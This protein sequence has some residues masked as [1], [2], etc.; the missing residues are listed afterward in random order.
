MEITSYVLV[1]L[2][3]VVDL[4]FS[5]LSGKSLCNAAQ[6]CSS[7]NTA[8]N[9][10][11]KKRE[12]WD[13]GLVSASNY[14]EE[15]QMSSKTE[16]MFNELRFQPDLILALKSVES[17]TLTSDDDF[18]FMQHSIPKK[19]SVLSAHV[20]GVIGR[21]KEKKKSQNVEIEYKNAISFLCLGPSKN[22]NYKQF[23]ISKK[24]IQKVIERP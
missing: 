21:K 2:S 23:F 3:P 11:M 5:Y 6:V 7:W 22:L 14:L 24:E 4:I 9:R 10:E 12:W 16:D 19:C 8:K 1:N 18:L 13:S 17:E 15:V 20:G